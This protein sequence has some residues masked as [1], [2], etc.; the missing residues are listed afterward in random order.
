[1]I[2]KADACKRQCIGRCSENAEGSRALEELHLGYGAVDIEGRSLK[3]DGAGCGNNTMISRSGEGDCR[4]L[5]AIDIQS[6]ALSRFLSGRIAHF[7]RHWIG[8]DFRRAGDP[9]DQPGDGVDIHT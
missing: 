5:V 3:C 1:M 4:R 7:D 9:F 6:E 8:T 2:A